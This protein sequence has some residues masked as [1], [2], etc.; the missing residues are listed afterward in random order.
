MPLHLD[1]RP[2]TLDEVVGNGTVVQALKA[3]MGKASPNRS[4][5]LIGPAGCGKTTLGY[6]LARMLGAL[7][8]DERRNIGNFQELNASHDRGI[9]TIREMSEAMRR[10]PMRNPNTEGPVTRVWLFDECHMLTKDSKEALLKSL[11]QPPRNSWLIFC[12]SDPA[13]LFSGLKDPTA[14][15]RRFT[16][17]QVELLNND[18]IKGL[19]NKVV[20]RER[21]RVPPDI[22]DMICTEAGGSPGMALNALDKVIDLPMEDMA[23]AV[24]RWADRATNVATLCRAMMAE[25]KKPAKARKWPDLCKI[26][27]ELDEEDAETIRRQVLEWFRKILLGGDAS[28]YLIMCEFE[29]PYYDVGKAGLIL[30]V[31]RAFC[32]Q[33]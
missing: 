8:D 12:T 18:L 24:K 16:E 19:L 3:H 30:S 32:L 13:K 9:E 4:L 20:R 6:I 17:F 21:K 2:Q 29:A 15:R 22:I 31:F 33:E 23:K 1:Y 27:A 14:M 10:P 7:T 28:V 26:V 5:L 25:L 11:E